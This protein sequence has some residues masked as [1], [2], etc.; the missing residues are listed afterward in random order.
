MFP[1][2]QSIGRTRVTSSVATSWADQFHKVVAER[3]GNEC[4][5]TRVEVR[6]CDAVHL[7]AHGKGDAVRYS[8]AQFVFAHHLH[9]GSTLRLIP[10]AAH[11][12]LKEATLY[13]RSTALEMACFCT[14]P[15]TV[16]WVSMLHS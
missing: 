7:L 10:G 3:D 11:E 9:G 16:C 14:P 5:L 6:L 1:V 13:A 2:D 8:Y 12:T 4:V 15:L